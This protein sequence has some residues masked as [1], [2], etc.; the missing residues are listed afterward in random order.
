MQEFHGHGLER[1]CR[2]ARGAIKRLVEH[3]VLKE[4]SSRLEQHVPLQEEQPYPQGKRHCVEQ[5]TSDTPINR[6]GDK[7]EA[8]TG[9]GPL[10]LN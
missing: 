9:I 3:L 10:S 2:A 8:T 1:R 4:K 5:L 6:L 7:R